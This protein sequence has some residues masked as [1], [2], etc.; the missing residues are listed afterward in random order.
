M[1]RFAWVVLCFT[2]GVGLAFE[3]PG[4][5]LGGA[6]GRFAVSAD[7]LTVTDATTRL[8]WQRDGAG[9]R[10]NCA[11]SPLCTLSEAS[12]YCGALALGGL[13]TWRLP[14]STELKSLVEKTPQRPTYPKINHAAFPNTPPERF[15]TFERVSDNLVWGISFLSNGTMITTSVSEDFRVRCVRGRLLT[16]DRFVPSATPP[17]PNAT[18]FHVSAD[19]LTVKDNYTSLVWQRHGTGPRAGCTHPETCTWPEAYAYC[20]RLSIGGASRWRLPEANEFLAIVDYTKAD[21]AIDP[22]VFPNQPAEWFW[23]S[24]SYANPESLPWFVLFGY[25]SSKFYATVHSDHRVRC[26]R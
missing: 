18:R 8:A 2:V 13:S 21:P 22:A 9:A 11:H 6:K 10:P 3:V 15:W 1:A 26:V 17:V 20:E 19:G 12:T 25:G 23:T 4:R 16:E 24:S 14:S 7:G 5:A